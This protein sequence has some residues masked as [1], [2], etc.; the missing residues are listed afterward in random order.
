VRRI[1][2]DVVVVFRLLAGGRHGD[3]ARR[4]ESS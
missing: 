2:S 3:A 4:V 1:R